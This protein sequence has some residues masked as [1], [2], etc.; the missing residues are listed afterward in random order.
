MSITLEKPSTAVAQSRAESPTFGIVRFPGS[1]CDQD[2]FH[3]VQDVLQMPAKYLWHADTDL[4]GVDIVVLPGGFSYGDYLRTGAVAR[5]APIMDKVREHIDAGGLVIGICNG[6]QVLCEAG[7]LPGALVRNQ[8]CKFICKYLTLRV[9]NNETPFTT[10]YQ[11]GDLLRIPIAH[12]E[13]RY[14]CDEATYQELTAG[15]RILF[16]YADPD[17]NLTEEANPNGSMYHIA[18][19]ANASFNVVGMMPHPE[20]AC[21]KILGSADGLGIFRSLVQ[22]LLKSHG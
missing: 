22:A 4:Q 6:F 9:E 18:G 20:R 2:A 15:N 13:G 16:R 19:I 1:N 7:I 3:A 8:Y 17:G 21:E 11:K 10:T 12:G 5:F 14:V